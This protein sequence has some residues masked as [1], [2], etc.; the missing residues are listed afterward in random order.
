MINK[1]EWKLVSSLF[2]FAQHNVRSPGVL[3]GKRRCSTGM[4]LRN[5]SIHDGQH[6]RWNITIFWSLLVDLVHAQSGKAS[7]LSW[8]LTYK[9]LM[10]S[11]TRLRSGATESIDRFL[12]LFR[13]SNSLTPFGHTRIFRSSP[14]RTLLSFYIS[15]FPTA[16]ELVILSRSFR[17][18]QSTL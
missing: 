3:N 11:A 16:A 2:F 13:F 12:Q 4:M 10:Q 17:V 5:P 1:I 6:V 8:S 9:I 14:R 7:L 15:L 18:N